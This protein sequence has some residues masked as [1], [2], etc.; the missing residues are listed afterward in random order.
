MQPAR[1]C[2]LVDGCLDLGS[3]AMSAGCPLP[4]SARLPADTKRAKWP[5][6]AAQMVTDLL[7]PRPSECDIRG[8]CSDA[9]AL[10]CLLHT[11]WP[12]FGEPA[13]EPML[14]EMKMRLL[15]SSMGKKQEPMT[16]MASATMEDSA[17]MNMQLPP[18]TAPRESPR[19]ANCQCLC[20]WLAVPRACERRQRSR[21]MARSLHDPRWPCLVP[22]LDRKAP[23]SLE[24]RPSTTSDVLP[25][26]LWLQSLMPD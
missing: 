13:G 23:Q 24:R 21:R 14:S 5:S 4:M 25:A 2:P 6:V 20:R 16:K 17:L 3:R 18:T 15:Q 26:K 1:R 19:S 7:L 9:L 11:A 12:C 22:A 10:H 8:A